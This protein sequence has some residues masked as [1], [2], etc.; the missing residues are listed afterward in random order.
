[1]TQ[2][3]RALLYSSGGAFPQTMVTGYDEDTSTF[4]VLKVDQFGHLS[5]DNYIWDS[6]N[7]EWIPSAGSP[8]ATNVGVL[9]ASSVRI[10]PATEES[11]VKLNG[12]S[13]PV[14]DYIDLGYTST[15]LT[16]VVYKL[17][18]SGG[19]TVATLTLGYSGSDL[20]SV[21]RS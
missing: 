6:G 14:Y 11:L 1:M 21:T 18:G 13:I 15:N 10:N 17:G 16:S 3:A 8:V 7:L 20:V 19:T 4:N 12:F 5:N 9:N 2:D